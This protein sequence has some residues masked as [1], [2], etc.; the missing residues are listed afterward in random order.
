MGTRRYPEWTQ[1]END[2]IYN[3]MYLLVATSER[4][5]WYHNSPDMQNVPMGTDRV[6]TYDR[7]PNSVKTFICTM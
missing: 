4:T 1:T 2:A 5:H 7:Y 6:G 3:K